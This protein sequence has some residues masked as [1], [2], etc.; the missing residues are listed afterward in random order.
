MSVKTLSGDLAIR[1]ATDGVQLLGGYGYTREYPQERRMRDARQAAELLGSPSRMKLSLAG[2][3]QA[4]A[5][6]LRPQGRTR[7]LFLLV[8][9][10]QEATVPG[11]LFLLTPNHV[12]LYP[13]PV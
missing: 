1:A 5:Q 10:T 13:V 4:A 11:T 6:R 12:L 7:C 8:Y 9:P 3:C 2:G